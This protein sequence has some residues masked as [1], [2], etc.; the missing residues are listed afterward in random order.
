MRL[1][2]WYQWFWVT[3]SKCCI[4]CVLLI[5]FCG[6]MTSRNGASS[7][8]SHLF[9]D[10][11]D[12]RWVKLIDWLKNI[13]SSGMVFEE[14]RVSRYLRGYSPVSGSTIYTKRGCW[15][16]WHFDYTEVKLEGDDTRELAWNWF[17]YFTISFILM[18]WQD[19]GTL[20]FSS[21]D[22]VNWSQMA[23]TASGNLYMTIYGIGNQLWPQMSPTFQIVGLNIGP[24]PQI[25]RQKCS[26]RR[27][28]MLIKMDCT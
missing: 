15:M 13:L 8:L 26:Q 25:E 9:V 17:C 27:A 14:K 2:Q 12:G 1:P 28:G 11:F 16:M 22:G 24:N 7:N 20:I 10:N 6:A 4:L 19:F 3:C 23:R 5:Y 18:N 21:F